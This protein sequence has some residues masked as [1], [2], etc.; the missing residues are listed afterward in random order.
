MTDAL[1]FDGV[2]I[3]GA[4]PVGLTAAVSLA[5]L[6]VPV[7]VLESG[8]ELSS[9][10]RASTFHPSSLELLSDLGVGEDLMRQGLMVDRVQFRDRQKGAVAELDYSV[11]AE[12]TPFPFRVQ[13]EQS[14]LTPLLLA[15]LEQLGGGGVRFDHVVTSAQSDGDRV[16]VLGTS[17][18]TDF[19][20]TAPYVIAADG[21][22]S[23]IRS[24]LGIGFH[25]ESY[26]ERHLV[27]STSLDVRSIWSDVALVTY[28]ADPEHWFALIRTPDHWRITIP[29][30][31]D[32]EAARAESSEGL[33]SLLAEVLGTSAHIPVLHS[34][35]YRVSRRLAD[36]F[37]LGRCFLAGD[38][39][40]LNNPFGGLGMNSGILDAFF[41]AKGLSSDIN[42]QPE[43]LQAYGARHRDLA[44]NVVGRYSN[45]NWSALSQKDE[46]ERRRWRDALANL[47]RDRAQVTAYLREVSLLNA[48]DGLRGQNPPSPVERR[49]HD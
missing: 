29:I 11:L 4:G 14:K 38:A 6:G 20:Y 3:V 5:T 16:T 47:A 8:A 41:L 18:K 46:G 2:L 13:L 12:H 42:G 45:A 10:S 19:S 28:I 48:L 40:H 17:G 25:G 33:K 21:G 7:T 36:T 39:A 37:S 15:R 22:G 31:T 30:R 34:S 24:S 26:P 43:A 44:L 23:A 9:Q 32:H 27:V 1:T 49:A 35:L